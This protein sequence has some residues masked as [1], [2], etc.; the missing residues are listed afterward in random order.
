M[1]QIFGDFYHGRIMRVMTIRK[2][3]NERVFECFDL[4]LWQV[5]EAEFLYQLFDPFGWG[6][7]NLWWLEHGLFSE[8]YTFVNRFGV[9][10]SSA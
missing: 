1:L 3:L 10:I 7:K 5:F 9:A 8:T 2:L 4:L 6:L